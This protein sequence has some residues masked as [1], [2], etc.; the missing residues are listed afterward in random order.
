MKIKFITGTNRED[1]DPHVITED[2]NL[3]GQG[4]T[5]GNATGLLPVKLPGGIIVTPQLQI[6]SA[7]TKSRR[8]VT[9]AVIK[10]SIPYAALWKDPATATLQLDPK[11]GNGY[12]SMHVVL[13]MP[14][15]AASD[16][17]S[18]D[19]QVRLGSYAQVA[20]ISYLLRTLL[21]DGMAERIILSGGEPA[22]STLI[23]A[24]RPS[25]A[26]E[27]AVP[28]VRPAHFSAQ[29]SVGIDATTVASVPANLDN[30]VVRVAQG[31]APLSCADINEK[32]GVAH[33]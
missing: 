33:Y 30:L 14:P 31:L 23:S 7:T 3:C 15:S 28:T 20:I 18:T 16:L 11:R 25:F 5:E 10:V 2:L 1:D 9:S 26:S 19:S 8:G 27:Y 21:S 22:A 4:L 24:D 29:G 32:V 17:K 13:A 12:L 6:T